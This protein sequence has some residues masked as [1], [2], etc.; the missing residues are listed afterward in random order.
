MS[1][2]Q[3]FFWMGLMVIGMTAM[4]M[5]IYFPMWGGMFCGPKSGVTEEDYYMSGEAHNHTFRI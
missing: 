5:S 3:G 4:Y 2:T 1:P